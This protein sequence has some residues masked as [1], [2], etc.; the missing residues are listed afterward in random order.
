[1]LQ[2]S[3]SEKIMAKPLKNCLFWAQFAQERGHYGPCPK[4]KKI[5]FAEITK[6]DHQLSEAFNFI[7]ISYVLAEIWI[8]FYLECCFLSKKC[9]F[10]LKQL[11]YVSLIHFHF[12]LL[13]N[14]SAVYRWKFVGILHCL[15]YLMLLSWIWI[16]SYFR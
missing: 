10:Q 5:F 6:A 1:M 3:S 7:E 11:P 16:Y 8:F 13:P 2:S 4:I 14:I 15:S 12:F 9:H